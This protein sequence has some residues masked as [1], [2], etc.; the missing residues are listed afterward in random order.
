MASTSETGTATATEETQTEGTFLVDLLGPKIQGQ[1]GLVDTQDLLKCDVVSLYFSAHWCPPCRGFTPKLAETYNKVTKAGK[2]WD[3]IFISSDKDQSQFNEY[4]KTMPWKALPY[5]KRELKAKLSKK[6]KV[7]GIPQLTMIDPRNG[8]LMNKEGRAAISGDPN[9]DKFPWEN[10]PKSFNDIMKT[11][12]LKDDN[13][14]VD[15]AE[16]QAKC[17]YIAV[18]TSAHWCPPCRGFT[19]KLIEWYKKYAEQFKMECIFNSWDNDTDQFKDYFK[20]MPWVA[21]NWDDK[22]SKEALDQLFEIQGIPS[23][24]VVDAKTGKLITS[25]ARAGVTGD[26]EGFPWEKKPVAKLDGSVVD[27]LNSTPCVYARC[28]KDNADAVIKALTPA[29]EHYVNLAKKAGEWPSGMDVEFIVDDGSHGLSGRVK[30]LLK[31]KKEEM[32]FIMDLSAKKLYNCTD[33]T[34]MPVSEAVASKF[35][36]NFRAGS[37]KSRQL[38]L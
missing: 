25:S 16:I 27:A 7:Q 14:A 31:L 38:D 29:A 37:V 13:G 9:G 24:V 19:P 35:L 32:F 34:E 23:L 8:D 28:S 21:K 1:D 10:R 36:E 33:V 4:F 20:D 15:I 26:P 3:V 30:D 17:D 22:A 2:K 12:K 18:Y 6:F 11:I 5:D